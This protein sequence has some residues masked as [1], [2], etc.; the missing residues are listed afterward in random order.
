MGRHAHGAA[1]L[2]VHAARHRPAG[3]RRLPGRQRVRR[4]QRLRVR[5]LRRRHAGAGG[6]GRRRPPAGAPHG[7]RHA[8]M[9]RRRA[10]VRTDRGQPGPEGS[11]R[12]PAALLLPPARTRHRPP[13]RR[14]PGRAAPAR[15]GLL[16]V[17][18]VA[19][20]SAAAGLRRA[21]ASRPAGGARRVRTDPQPPAGTGRTAAAAGAPGAAGDALGAQDRR[22]R[23][24]RHLPPAAI[25]R[26]RALLHAR[27]PARRPAQGYQLEGVQ[28]HWRADHPHLPG[29]RTGD[30]AAARRAPPL[31]PGGPGDA[32]LRA[33]PRLPEELAA[34]VPA[35]GQGRALRLHLPRRHRRRRA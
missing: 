9:G 17:G 6:V 27:I 11:R 25:L 10:A 30:P 24:G 14:Q 18:G 23:G 31:P 35:R 21:G 19:A 16:G 20:P 26:R 29:Q 4:G 7:R 13:A 33:P 2:P 5:A 1:L 32:G 12:P 34:G 3:S 28:P 22:G 8:G 15:G